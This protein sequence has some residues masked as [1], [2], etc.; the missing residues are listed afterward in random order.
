MQ[1]KETELYEISCAREHKLPSL[2]TAMMSAAGVLLDSKGSSCVRGADFVMIMKLALRGP[3]EGELTTHRPLPA[4]TTTRQPFSVRDA[5]LRTS[6]SAISADSLVAACL[7]LKTSN[8]GIS[9]SFN[10][11][12]SLTLST[13]N[14]PNNVSVRLESLNS[15]R[16]TMLRMRTSNNLLVA[17]VSL[18]VPAESDSE[19]EGCRFDVMDTTSNGCLTIGFPSAPR[20]ATLE[21]AVCTSSTKAEVASASVL[22]DGNGRWDEDKRHIE[23]VHGRSGGRA[24]RGYIYEDENG[25]KKVGMTLLNAPV[26]V[27]V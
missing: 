4:P 5:K 7:T 26:V 25:G 20:R 15:G 11:S 9:S 10:S 3:R 22:R 14:V 13:S 2:Q 6:N 17:H 16:P 27:V 12:D 8:A 24:V 23:Y 1:I 18:A 21:L 19:S